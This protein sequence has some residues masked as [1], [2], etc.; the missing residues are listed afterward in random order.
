MDMQVGV[1]SS[2]ERLSE[3]VGDPFP[4]IY[5]ELFS[6]NPE[7]EALFFLDTNGDVRGEMLA[8]AF[9]LLMQADEGKDMAHTL[10]KA[11][12]F[13]HDGYGVSE[14]QFDSFFSVIR[15][16]TKR[17]LGGDWSPEDDVAWQ[18]VVTGLLQR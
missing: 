8:Q 18:K 10:V 11:A 16:V 17:E 9:D 5:R 12:R 1:T 3:K 7:F 14:E 6:R 13:A 4:F 2:L 15:D